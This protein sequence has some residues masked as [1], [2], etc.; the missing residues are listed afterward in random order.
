M[1]PKYHTQENPYKLWTSQNPC[2][3]NRGMYQSASPTSWSVHKRA[4]TPT[5][6]KGGLLRLDWSQYFGKSV[7][8]VFQ[9]GKLHHCI[10]LTDSNET[11]HILPSA[12]AWNLS[13]IVVADTLPTSPYPNVL[14]LL[15]SFFKSKHSGWP[16]TRSSTYGWH[17][18]N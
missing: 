7:P 9:L 13:N 6:K 15:P 10:P 4:A 8:Q 17:S 1:S 18:L 2:L 5:F 12:T 3:K 11:H 14:S 16:L